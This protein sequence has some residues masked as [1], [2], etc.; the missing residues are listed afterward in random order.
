M[1]LIRALILSLLLAAVSGCSPPPE[2]EG[3]LPSRPDV[4]AMSLLP[5][6]KMQRF[7]WPGARDGAEVET[8]AG[9]HLRAVGFASVEEARHGFGQASD[10]LAMRSGSL[11]RSTVDIGALQFLRYSGK[12]VSGLVW[13][14]GTWLFGAEARDAASLQAVIRDSSAGGIGDP[15]L[16]GSP[17]ARAV[18]YT[19]PAI[20]TIAAVAVLAILL[21]RRLV[22]RPAAGTP[23][24]GQAAVR[25]RLL[26]LNAPDRPWSVRVGPEADLV[27]EWR[28][29]D[30]GWWGV[31]GKAGLKRAYRLRLYF[32]ERRHQCAGLDEFGEIDWSAGFLM[33]PRVRFQRRFFRG[34]QLVKVERE[35][36]YG[37]RTPTEGGAGKVLDYRFDIA[38]IKGP[39]IDAVC[40]AGWTYRPILWPRR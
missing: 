30:A 28:Y 4:T 25:Q 21:M 26:G 38:D 32:D 33:A 13:V 1:P 11:S 18:M 15:G 14:S 36:A 22:V 7:D 2:L 39:V 27:A 10:A 40:A 6:G 24:L 17:A 19:L 34:I 12:D 35:V 31:L 23:I 29:A 20:A 5:A 9:A 37:F 16:P 8:P 3:R